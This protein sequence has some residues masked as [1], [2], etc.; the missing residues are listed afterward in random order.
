MEIITYVLLGISL[1]ILL[2]SLFQKDP[3]KE[4]KE[5]ID[6]LTL[7][8]VQELYQVKKKL[9]IL[10]EELLIS[11]DQLSESAVTD[12]DREIH[13]IIKNQ[14][15]ALAQQGKPIEQIAVQSSLTIEDVFAILREYKDKEWVNE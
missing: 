3:Y 4:L 1:F 8:H 5:E 12:N 15:L 7:Q 6:H 10:E 9:K 2:L 13:D 14:V 11:N